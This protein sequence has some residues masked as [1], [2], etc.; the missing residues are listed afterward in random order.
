MVRL[1][2]F[3]LRE[4]NKVKTKE[5]IQSMNTRLCRRTFSVLASAL[6][7]LHTA[8]NVSAAKV[9]YD[10]NADWSDTQ[11]PNGAWSYDLNDTPISVFQTFWWGQAGWG[12][13]W[14]GDGCIIKGSYPEGQTDPWGNLIGPAH[15]WQPGDVM[16]AALS[17]PYGGD[18]TFL[19][20]KWTSP[21][22]G[23]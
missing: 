9:T 4:V 23:I 5:P 17:I 18:S 19:N 22:D 11:N 16:T 20:V 7:L 14:I 13:I 6:F 10:L 21:G 2:W 12:Y 15:D 8:S 1:I 3:S